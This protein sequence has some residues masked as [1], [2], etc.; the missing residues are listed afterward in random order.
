MITVPSD[1]SWKACNNESPF[2][3][4]HRTVKNIVV[5]PISDATV[6]TQ[7][8]VL[9]T[10]M[11]EIAVE[12]AVVGQELG[13]VSIQNVH[14]RYEDIVSGHSA[15]AC[16]ILIQSLTAITTNNKWKPTQ[17]DGDAKSIFKL[18][19]LESLSIYVNPVCHPENLVLRD[20]HSSFWKNSMKKA[21]ATFSMN[22]DEFEFGM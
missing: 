12:A 10:E 16:G 9:E 14:I 13:K 8:V 4:E 1:V 5:T 20:M 15:L 11:I 19:K 17:I 21:L 7:A 22:G 18:V 3:E 6:S 2:P